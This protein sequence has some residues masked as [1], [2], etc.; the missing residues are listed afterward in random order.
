MESLLNIKQAA[1]ILGVAPVTIRLWIS[2]KKIP[3]HKIGKL[4][5][6]VPSEIQELVE[7]T[8]VEA[9]P[10]NVDKQVATMLGISYKIPCRQPDLKQQSQ[11]GGANGPV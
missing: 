8:K 6:F 4:I 7:K 5:K 1:Q 2:Q 3:Y 11:K 9:E 10:E